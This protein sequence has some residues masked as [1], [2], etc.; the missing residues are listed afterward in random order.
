[1]AVAGCG[2]VASTNHVTTPSA[3]PTVVGRT[4]DGKTIQLASF[5]GH[6]LVVVFW[7]SWCGPCHDEQPQLNAAYARWT[8]RGVDFLGVDLRDS[9]TA[10]LQFQRQFHVP[11]ASVSDPDAMIAADYD[12]PAAPALAFVDALGHVGDRVL[13]GLGVMSDTEFDQELSALLRGA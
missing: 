2:S 1:M 10:G 4:L 13:G 6:P 7:G 12:I 3:Q 8:G 9:T 11:Y 5:R